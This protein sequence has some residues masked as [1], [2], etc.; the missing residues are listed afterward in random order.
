MTKKIM[1]IGLMALLLTGCNNVFSSADADENAVDNSSARPAKIATA[2]QVAINLPKSFP[3][4][5]KASRNAILSF[6]VDGQIED[7]PVRSGQILK[8]GDL[9]ARLDDT[10]YRNVVAA[11]QAAYDLAKISLERT[12]TLYEQAHVA[13]S[14][15]DTATTNYSSAEAALKSAKD[16]VHYTSLF[17]PFDGVVAKTNVERYQTVSAGT[18]II[19]FQDVKD[20]DIEFSVPEKLFLRFNPS[21]LAVMPKLNIQFDALPDKTFVATY[22]EI[23]TI[24]DSVTRSYKVTVTMPRPNTMTIFPGM[25]VTA[26]LNLAAMLSNNDDGGV[27]IPL[28]AVF[29]QNGKHWVWKVSDDNKTH[30]TEVNVYGIQDGSIRIS[31]GLK[32]GDR[33]IAIGVSYVTEGMEVRAFKKEDGL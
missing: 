17:A 5:T 1:L 30:K 21:K 11:Q 7:F 20:I 32:N 9:I 26:S 25:S 24:P 6:R 23:D 33:V 29:E 16:N 10:P 13:K 3:G 28:E 4:V 2:R 27:L 18:S 12:K 22:K 8:K 15:L 19:Q 14:T 31:K